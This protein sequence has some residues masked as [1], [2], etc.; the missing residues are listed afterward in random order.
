[1]AAPSADIDRVDL[2]RRLMAA[3]P[4]QRV[5]ALHDLECRL[6][7]ATPPPGARLAQAVHEFVARGMP[8]YSCV[9]PH[10]LAWVERAVE[11]WGRLQPRAESA[12]AAAAAGPRR[13]TDPVIS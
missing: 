8:F 1:M 7:H 3:E 6:E 9:D 11:N 12:G 4:M 2:R 10:Y 5:A 13:A